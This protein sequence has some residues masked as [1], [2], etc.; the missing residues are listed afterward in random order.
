MENWR[1]FGDMVVVCGD[2]LVGGQN[3]DGTTRCVNSSTGEEV[4]N[5]DIDII[6][7]MVRAIQGTEDDPD[8]NDDKLVDKLACIHINNIPLG[9]ILRAAIFNQTA[10]VA[11]KGKKNRWTLE[12]TKSLLLNNCDQQLRWLDLLI[13]DIPSKDLKE[14]VKWWTIGKGHYMF[15]PKKGIDG[16]FWG[17]KYIPCD[18]LGQVRQA[19]LL[20]KRLVENDLDYSQPWPGKVMDIY[21]TNK[22]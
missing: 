3:P 4:P 1:E 12:N 21:A 19:V 10:T 16:H 8:K 20:F 2:L 9:E 13:R 14:R 11:E 18:D 15:R 22:Q 17:N 5:D 7:E 6:V